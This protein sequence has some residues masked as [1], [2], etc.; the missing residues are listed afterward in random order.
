MKW[1]KLKKRLEESFS[2]TIR[3]RVQIYLTSYR[4]SNENSRVWIV[5]DGEE[6]ISLDNFNSIIQNGAYFNEL[7]PI[8]DYLTHKKIEKNERSSNKLY[9]NGEFSSFDFTFMARQYLQT[10]AYKSIQSTH[11]ILR[12]L[13]VLNKK[14]GIDKIKKLQY[15]ENPMVAYFA[16]FRYEA[17]NK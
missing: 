5:V 16:K 12:T 9:E 2:D 15:D 17:E 7:T 13:G 1:S 14:I 8:Q 11:P 10:P 4:D 6:K 3:K